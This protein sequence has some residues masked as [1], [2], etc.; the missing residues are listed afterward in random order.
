MR[1]VYRDFNQSL[2]NMKHCGNTSHT[3]IIQGSR[4]T[5]IKSIK[6]IISV[7]I[8]QSVVKKKFTWCTVVGAGVSRADFDL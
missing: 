1:S 6:R 8:T 4:C 3:T 5:V 2:L 7:K